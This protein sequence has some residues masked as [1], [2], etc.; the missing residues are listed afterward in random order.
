MIHERQN[1]MIWYLK[2]RIGNF[3]M[4]E[5]IAKYH[6]NFGDVQGKAELYFGI[7]GIGML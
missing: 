4:N 1:S 5:G 7:S 2:R 3:Q 6:P